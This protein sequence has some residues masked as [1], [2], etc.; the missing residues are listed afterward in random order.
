MNNKLIAIRVTLVFLLITSIF[1]LIDGIK[2]VDIINDY[3]PSYYGIYYSDL[4][5]IAVVELVFAIFILIFGL[6]ALI[7]SFA[8][9]SEKSPHN[10]L[11]F[12]ILLAAIQK[13]VAVFQ[14]ISLVNSISPGADIGATPVL[15]LV[16]LILAALLVVIAMFCVANDSFKGAG[17]VGIVAALLFVVVMIISLATGDSGEAMAIIYSV[18][19]IISMIIFGIA[20][21]IAAAE[22]SYY[23]YRSVANHYHSAPK[24]VNSAST[25]TNVSGQSEMSTPLSKENSNQEQKGDDPAEA[26]KKLKQLFDTGVITEEEYQEKRKKYIDKL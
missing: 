3:N 19:F 10:M 23:Y 7:V 14:A 16:F 1:L 13:I 24:P 4:K 17:G 21:G 8:S 5:A 26:L 9:Q 12:V 20:S 6:I 2:A 22:G 18:L 11:L 15:M 25:P